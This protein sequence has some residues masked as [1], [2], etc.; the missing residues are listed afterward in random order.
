MTVCDDYDAVLTYDNLYHSYRQ[1]VKNVSWKPSIQKY[2]SRAA[3]EVYH[4]YVR[5]NNRIFRHDNFYEFNIIERGKK[6]HIRSVTIRERVVQRC[7]C[8]YSLVPAITRSFVYDNG[9][10]MLNKGYTFAIRRMETHLH[11][12]YR[13]YGNDGYVLLF[14][15]SKFFDRVSHEVIQRIIEKTYTDEEM[16]WIVMHFVSAFGE[17]GLGLGSQISQVLALTSANELDHLVKE[18]L[19]IKYY[20][21]YM[22]DGYLIHHDKECLK[23]CLDEIQQICDRLGIVLNR[24]KTRIAK[25]S[26]GFTFLK[27]RFYLTETGRV[28]KKI[29]K[30]S[31]VKMRRKLK[32]FRR[33]LDDGK[34][35]LEDIEA[36]FQ[37]WLA[38][39]STFDAFHTML[40]MTKLY[41][42]LFG[43]FKGGKRWSSL[44]YLALAMTV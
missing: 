25:L 12:Y 31:V 9:A 4:N 29:Y 23:H 5:L 16:K 13:K 20:G 43:E 2:K 26:N 8:D 24:K 42:E 7:L 38:Y 35:G 6:R 40:N 19:R 22:D 36:S 17:I 44:N 11:K 18:R 30:R 34:M 28:V 33:L 32:T 41:I 3:M 27:V 1:C 15:F 21:R 39:A 14:D 37:S 10:S